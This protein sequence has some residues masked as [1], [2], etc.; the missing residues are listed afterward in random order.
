MINIDKV[1]GEGIGA[2]NAIPDLEVVEF[3][4]RVLNEDL[5][6]VLINSPY[7][8]PDTNKI[9]IEKF[10]NYIKSSKLNKLV[11]LDEYKYR[12]FVHGSCQAFDSFWMRHNNKR[13][14]CFKGE[15]FY[16]Q[17]NWKKFHKWCYLEDDD[18][19]NRN[20][21]VVISLPFSDYCKEHPKMKDMLDVCE[22]LGVPVLI[23]CA[24]YVIARDINFDFTEYGCIEEITF[25]LSKGFHSATRLR[26]GVRYSKRHYD[27]NIDIMNEW[28]QY[29][30]LSAYLGS[31][32]LSHF[33]EDYVM[34]KF[35]DKQLKFCKENNLIPSDCVPF[36]FGDEEYKQ[37]NRGTEVNRIC[38]SYLIGD[39]L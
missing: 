29:S 9:F 4:N 2:A 34:N 7:F 32:L 38:I 8:L 6:G 17:A 5:S 30:H 11:G 35:R 28:N 18:M 33:P 3:W 10:D 12:S 23:D 14:R 16:H 37:F 24:Y 1:P 31:K 22:E 39:K 26:A 19:I 25:S 27:D 15:F 13:F 20:D 36:A 21:A